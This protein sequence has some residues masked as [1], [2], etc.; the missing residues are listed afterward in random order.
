[1]IKENCLKMYTL[2]RSISVAV[3]NFSVYFNRISRNISDK[4]PSS[5]YKNFQLKR[6]LL[7]FIY[8]WKKT[9]FIG[10]RQI[11]QSGKKIVSSYNGDMV[12]V[13]IAIG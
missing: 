5:V 12:L 2:Y 7:H 8:K 6:D 1:M 9:F 3:F 4:N 10:K 13:I 11:L